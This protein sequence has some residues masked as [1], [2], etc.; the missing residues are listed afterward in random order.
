MIINIGQYQTSGVSNVSLSG[1][2]QKIVDVEKVNSFYPE[3]VGSIYGYNIDTSQLF[4]EK[5]SERKTFTK[6]VSGDQ[7]L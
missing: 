6:K 5:D 2:S 3:I 4:C 1:T 7:Q